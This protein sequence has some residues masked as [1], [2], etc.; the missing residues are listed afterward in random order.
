MLEHKATKKDLH[1]SYSQI[2]MRVVMYHRVVAPL[3]IPLLIAVGAYML[4]TG[5]LALYAN[6]T[7]GTCLCLMALAAVNAVMR[8]IPNAGKAYLISIENAFGPKTR[9]RVWGWW[10]EHGSS[11]RLDVV[12]IA[13][14]E[15]EL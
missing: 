14:Q 11:P 4:P 3:A 6:E 5:P 7:I 8:V 13:I 12:Q 9:A 10:A 1:R 2:G 15:G